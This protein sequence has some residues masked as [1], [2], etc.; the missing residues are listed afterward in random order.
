M[1]DLH[2]YFLPLDDKLKEKQLLEQLLGICLDFS[3]GKVREGAFLKYASSQDL[4]DMIAEELPQKGSGMEKMI[5]T[6]N[7]PIG[8]FSISQSDMDFFAFPDSGNAIPAIFAD[9]YSKFLNQNLIAVSRSAPIATFVEIQLIEWL[10]QL[11]GYEYKS[12]ND[13]TSL[14]EVSGMVTSGGH[15]SNHVAMLTALNTAF[16]QIKDNGLCSLDFQPAIIMAGDI[17]HYSHSSAAHHL[18]IGMEGILMT[19]S[20]S[21]CKTSIKDVEDKLKN[22]PEGK[23]V[24]MVVGVAGNSRTTGIDDL[25]KLAELCERYGVWFHVDACHGGNLLFSKKHKILL[26]GI[27]R[28]DS[29]SLDPHK[30][31]FSPYPLS[32]VMFK[33]RDAL[34]HFTRYEEKV[35][36]G[37][38]WDLGYI[39]PFYGSRGFESL[40][41]WILIKTLGMEKLEDII[42]ERQVLA[43]YCEDLIEKSGHFCIL[44]DME[45]YRMTFVYYPKSVW[46][47]IGTQVLTG[48]QKENI[49]NIID[50]YTHNINEDLYRTGRICLDEFQFHDH[51]NLTRLGSR[52]KF[53]VMSITLGNPKQTKQNIRRSL[54][55][56]FVRAEQEEKSFSEKV[57]SV[58]KSNVSHSNKIKREMFGPAGWS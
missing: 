17:S 41:L 16:P 43:R 2:D 10:R 54:E 50:E 51:A 19:G 49:K 9:I 36:K 22:P 32:F 52:E 7:D 57:D 4:K 37:L 47:K 33:K 21:D 3:S 18:G 31:L 46:K 1:S 5:E 34:V 58:I 29:V 30:G 44:N 39:N 26:K 38:S 55:K 14:A 53:V 6:L 28:A 35:R 40:K 12:L 24:F 27:S 56:L 42:N 23:K 45:F 48:E 15:M 8:K 11:I 13:I 20:T 25:E